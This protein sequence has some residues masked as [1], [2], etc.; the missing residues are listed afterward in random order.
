MPSKWG[1]LVSI[2]LT[3]IAF[4]TAVRGF[5]FPDLGLLIWVAWLPFL[6]SLYQSGFKNIGRRGFAFC[7]GI[8]AL[9]LYWLLPA[10]PAYG[11]VS[12]AVALFLF[13][14]V[15]TALALYGAAAFWMARFLTLRARIP[16][17]F[18]IA[19]TWTAA[20]WLR[21]HAPLNGFPWSNL[22]YALGGFPAFLQWLP[23]FGTFFTLLVI[24]LVNALLAEIGNCWMSWRRR[25]GLGPRGI[26]RP[27][28]AVAVVM[29]V[30]GIGSAAIYRHA[31]RVL[32]E[33]E[34]NRPPL[35]VALIQGN[36]PQSD[37]WSP[38]M[39]DGILER[40]TVLSKRAL[41]MGAEL[42][43]WPEAA[44]PFPI[45]KGEWS[46]ESL[47]WIPENRGLLFGALTWRDEG[48]AGLAY[49]NGALFA[50]QGGE[51]VDGGDKV[52]LV[53]F[54]EYIPFRRLLSRLS[55]LVETVGD[56]TPGAPGKAIRTPFGPVGI[57]ICYEDLFSRLSRHLRESGAQ[58]LVNVT[59][60]AWYEKNSAALQHVVYS[61]FRAA[62]N[63]RYLLRATNTGV[64][65]L[66][67]PLGR[68]RSRLSWFEVG[69]LED[70]VWPLQDSDGLFLSPLGKG[71]WAI[72]WAISLFL[73]YFLIRKSS[74][75]LY[76]RIQSGKN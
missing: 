45:W 57:L 13:M 36:I 32:G 31:D 62:E 19:L 67:D 66:I 34:K 11:G 55:P 5:R 16:F 74:Q 28:I 75:E 60:D 8:Y 25:G 2:V 24:I 14:G 70:W 26:W 18:A 69:I 58:L 63:R 23:S 49:F 39:A 17:P 40:Y 3:A 38:A 76:A 15:C 41:E 37:K 9:S 44:Y 65:A 73:V 20:E 71:G 56:F 48:E 35:R 33:I 64:T 72:I 46:L 50:R 27:S 12:I 68:V 29:A 51:L 43:V 30:F 1:S 21:E 59:N 4:P 10:M 42:L 47:A 54:G 6:F 7:F 53:P 52:N 61:Q 22:A